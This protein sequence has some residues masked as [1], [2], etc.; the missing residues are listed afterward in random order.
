MKLKIFKTDEIKGKIIA[1]PSKSYTHRAI[2]MSS[3]SDG[4]SK[5]DNALLSGDT[6]SS[7][8][9]CKTLGAKIE[10]KPD[11]SLIIKGNFPFN[12]VNNFIDVGNSG[13]TIR[14]MTALCG[15]FPGEITLTGDSSIQQRPMG[16]L[17][18]SLKNLGV[19]CKSEKNNN[20]PPI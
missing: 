3:L 13:T 14:I 6:I 17:L 10:T 4:K 19:D 1:P 15:Y 8:N 11:N 18:K 12:P 9:A 16:P 5:I 20:C 7:I 2:I